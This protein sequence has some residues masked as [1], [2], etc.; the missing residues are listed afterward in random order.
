M[1][2]IMYDCME[3][4][5]GVGGGGMR[6]YDPMNALFAGNSRTLFLK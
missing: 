3:I 2:L 4:T 6:L 5:F 1:C